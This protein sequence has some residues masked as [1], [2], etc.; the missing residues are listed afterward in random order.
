MTPIKGYNILMLPNVV[1]VRN[2]SREE[3]KKHLELVNYIECEGSDVKI[4][5]FRSWV[6][7][8]MDQR[9][10]EIVIWDAHLL[11]TECQNILLK[12]LEEA[13]RQKGIY[14][15][16]E[17]ENGLLPTVLSRCVLVD[18]VVKDNA[19]NIYWDKVMRCW[20]DG[21]KTCLAVADEIKVTED[22]KIMIGEVISKVRA[23]LRN[24]VSERRLKLLELAL[25]AGRLL[26][27][28]GINSKLV[29]EDFLLTS[30][31]LSKT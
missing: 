23:G 2:W 30:W 29:L 22:A 15:I 6:N 19:E 18:L 1:A 31:R 17:Y 9:D 7:K 11:S 5:D 21:P 20:K 12:P 26:R 4:D 16:V 3:I 24:E 10:R 13:G 28:K 27:F 25:E 8:V 14:L